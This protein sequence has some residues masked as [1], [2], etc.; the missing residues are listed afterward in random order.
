MQIV[1]A[2]WLLFELVFLYLYV[3]ETKGRTLEETA[4]LF[5]GVDATT[6]VTGPNHPVVSRGDSEK[7]I[8]KGSTSDVVHLESTPHV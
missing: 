1:Y 2:C 3:I 7:S 6:L 8:D 5:D 4:A